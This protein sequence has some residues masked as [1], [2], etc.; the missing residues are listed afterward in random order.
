MP[1]DCVAIKTDGT[2]GTS[3][4][5]SK[6][7]AYDVPLAKNQG[8]TS[9]TGLITFTLVTSKKAELSKRYWISDGSTIQKKPAAEMT[10]GT[11]ERLTIRFSGFQD[12]L[13]K[14]TTKQAAVYGSHSLEH[15]DKVKLVTAAKADPTNEVLA[16]TKAFYEYRIGG[17]ILMLDYDPSQYGRTLTPDELLFA[18]ESIHPELK[19]TAWIIRGSVSAGVHL[20]G[21]EPSEIKGFH[22]YI[23]VSDASDIPRYGKLLFDRLW[24]NGF[25]Y[26]ALA[27]NGNKLIRTVIDG[28]VFSAERLDFICPPVLSGEG[29]VYTPPNIIYQD[30]DFLDTRS[31]LDLTNDELLALK[32]LQ[33]QAKQDIEPQAAIALDAWKEGTINAHVDRGKTR[34]QATAT[35]EKIISSGF[36]DLYGDYLLE[37]TTGTVAVAEVLV[38]PQSFDD[39]ALADPIEGRS[40]GA[41]TA[42]FYWNNGKPVINS[43]AHGGVTYFL[44]KQSPVKNTNADQQKSVNQYPALDKR[45]CYRCFDVWWE[46]DE[47]NR[48]QPGVWSF[49]AKQGAADAQPQLIDTWLCGVMRVSAIARDK[50]NRSFGNVLEFKN[51]LNVSQ[52]WNMPTRLMAG[53]GDELLKELL[54]MGLSFNYRQRNDIAAYINS[55]HPDKTMWSA[56]KVGW[57]DD[58]FILPDTVFGKNADDVMFQSESNDHKEYGVSGSLNDWQNHVAA[59][60]V[61]N[62]GLTFTLS[63]AFVGALLKL[64][65]VD[66]FGF[67]WF[68]PSSKGKT[69]GLKMASSTWGNWENYK[70]VWKT[71]ANGL[72]GAALLFND[73]LLALDEI[74]DGDPKEISEALYMLFNGTGKMRANVLGHARNVSTWR[75]AVLSNGELPIESH[76]AKKGITVQAGQLVR[77]LQIPIWG[78][79][80]AFD[81][82]HG[83]ESG[84]AFS[85]RVTKNAELYHGE[86]GRAYLDKLT[87]S[88]LSQLPAQLHTALEKFI[89]MNA[90]LSD[91][92]AR[93]AKSFALV[94]IAG[95]L[96]TDY[97]ITGWNS[98]AATQ[99][100]LLCFQKWRDYRGAGDIEPQ[101]IK[102]SVQAYVETFGDARFT[103]TADETRLHG[104]RAGYWREDGGRV[105]LFTKPG[106]Q[107]ATQGMDFNQVVDV[108]QN[109]GW[110]L[111]N[112]DGKR[113]TKV[114]LKI[115]DDAGTRFYA[116]RV[117][118]S[119]AE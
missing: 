114:R 70:R 39:K 99:A 6:G 17:G 86:A 46:D 58:K 109:E 68:G 34:E 33:D 3:G 7:V 47:G 36:Q 94:G 5:I 93:A 8:G 106:L 27:K 50:N 78:E 116:V 87:T 96:A 76:L 115:N 37:F 100:A 74:G 2:C 104:E 20:S 69:T 101:R 80:G 51:K 119:H 53:R 40:Y 35:V 22:I 60:C 49:S 107:Q 54:D 85:N 92:E 72:E 4:T 118:G 32:K 81:E 56:N 19:T 98:G 91:Q 1:K 43:M 59:L 97:G 24:L 103:C 64:C 57:M 90:S 108:L 21:K 16:R 44:H 9:G 79:H 12:I 15:Q 73:G 11:A 77:F 67:H 84:W 30:G 89:S 38:K 117:G 111:T 75:V 25:G 112:G 110:L 105:W 28:A 23:P 71:T 10:D 82:L 31:L 41:T 13:S 45:P 62:A 52:Q 88:D 61:G 65:N 63:T 18:L 113:T 14:A 29:L 102:E 95:E 26:I 48:K 83:S 55:Q 66:S 42:K